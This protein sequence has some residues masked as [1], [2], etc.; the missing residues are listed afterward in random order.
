M[1]IDLFNDFKEKFIKMAKSRTIILAIVFSALF[2]VIVYRLFQLQ[3]VN[4]ESY[5]ERF[6]LQIENERVT[7]GTRGNIYDVKGNLLAE[8]IVAYNITIEDN[9]LYETT[10][11]RHLTLNSTIYKLDK[12]VE[13]NGDTLITN[14]GIIIDEEGNY[15]FASVGQT[16]L[17]F[18]AD[19]YGYSY[20]DQLKEEEENATADEMMEVLSS[21]L[22]YGLVNER[23][24]AADY[25]QYQIP[26][27]LSKEEVLKIISIR[28]ALALNSYQR[29]IAVTVAKDIGE[30]TMAIVSENAD[31]L[32]GVEIAESTTRVYY[33]SI[34]FSNIIGYTGGISQ[35]ELAVYQDVDENAEYTMN[36]IV[37][38]D[39]IE[40]E[41]EAELR[42]SKGYEIVYVDNRGTELEVIS[43]KSPQAGNDIWLTIAIEDQRAAYQIAEQSLAGIILANLQNILWQDR[44][45]FAEGVDNIPIPIGD[46]YYGL[47]NNNI[48][49]LVHFSSNTASQTEQTVYN[50]FLIRQEAVFKRVAEELD[51]TQSTAYRDLP[52]E[53]QAYMTYIG[54]DLLNSKEILDAG[55]IDPTDS[56]YM[57][58]HTYESISLR[59]YLL[60]AI[61][62]NWIDLSRIDE[63]YLNAKYLDSNEIYEELIKYI[64]DTLRDDI[65]FSK[66]IYRYMVVD[67]T[68]T[69]TQV[70]VMLYDQGVLPEDLETYNQLLTGE[71]S[72]Y[73]FMYEKIQKL[74]ITPAQLALEPCSESIV[75]T[76]P[77]TGAV[78][79]CMTY[80]GYD[81]NRLANTMDSEY[82]YRL[83]NDL[84]SP[85]YSK[86]TREVT[87]PGS[88][89]KLLTAIV[90]A[91]ENIVGVDEVISCAG[92]YDK[93]AG[94]AINCWNPYGHHE[95]KMENAIGVS[96]NYYFNEIGFRLGEDPN[97]PMVN[98]EGKVLTD[99][100]KGIAAI[101]KY[102]RMFGLGE[103]SGIEVPESL[104]KISNADSSRSA[105]GQSVNAFTTTQLAKYVTGITNRGTVYDLTLIQKITDY[106]GKEIYNLEPSLYNQVEVADATWNAVH[107][108][109]R[110]VMTDSEVADEVEALGLQ[111]A[112]KTGT[113]QQDK[114]KANHGL[115]IG[116][117]PFN[118]P[119]L[120]IA[121]RVTNGYS[122]KN[123]LAIAMT[124][125]KYKFDLVPK[126]TIFTGEATILEH[127]NATTD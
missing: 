82:F 4:G 57:N 34:Y 16:Q 7:N 88:T 68:L 93:I 127:N 72:A 29:Y 77:R 78:T 119:E 125:Y 30:Q 84:A 11:E 64:T 45:A 25:E 115:F 111:T 46:V 91:E 62:Q 15:A 10:L 95:L 75:T 37:G 59:E 56:V 27:T 51:G 112:G 117:A 76:D 90:G 102:A 98:E 87:A 23:Y 100:D 39:G 110:Q 42:G 103:N 74:E 118:N 35:E 43:V 120:T 6:T 107:N 21:S 70:S 86:A 97:N 85:F 81:N 109:M 5:Q 19:I 47:I 96:C 66:R 41:F 33:D 89:Y 1:R 116:Y 44:T 55:L 53:M 22:Y 104:P 73:S 2:G 124:Y 67:G 99:D 92:V 40:K 79:V 38:K 48:L 52:L 65:G 8:S 54:T 32:Q 126:E 9:G 105:M 12:I 101:E 114:T 61:S 108:G 121:V 58:W 49:D 50:N 80:P 60:H 63:D 20:I 69:G 94:P 24:T 123:A 18:K 13:D 26:S 122:S 17:R 3:I 28:Y 36:D 113:A 31:V 106:E 83:N 71:L 14:F